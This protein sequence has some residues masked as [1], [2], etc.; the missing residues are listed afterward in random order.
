M[1]KALT[2]T[3]SVGLAQSAAQLAKFGLLRGSEIIIL[4]IKPSL[5][6]VLFVSSR[7]LAILLPLGI[8]SWLSVRMGWLGMQA[9]QV[10]LAICLAGM[11]VRLAFGLLQWQSRVYILTNLR[12]LRIRGVVRVEMFQCSL[13][14]LKDVL[15]SV[16]V[17]E[18]LVGLGTI[19][20]V[21]NSSDKAAAYWQNI[22]RP[23]QVRQQIL[24]AIN[25]LK[26]HSGAGDSTD[27]P[28]TTTLPAKGV[29]NRNAKESRSARIESL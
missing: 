21:K 26:G 7:W 6:Y 25:S 18:R 19:G 9:Q 12:V 8:I 5:C 13:L 16:G 20:L 29:E 4:A 15:L 28:G 27:L 24:K 3:G 14:Q 22:R 17:A 11:V 23:E 10:L 2:Q 1:A